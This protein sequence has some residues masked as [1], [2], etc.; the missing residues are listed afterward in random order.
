MG[1]AQD[2]HGRGVVAATGLE[3]DEAVLDNIDAADAVG[4]AE[5]VERGEELDAVGVRLLGCDELR[6][7]A[8]LEM[9]GN[10]GGLVGGRERRLR[11]GPHVVRGGDVG[12][13]EDA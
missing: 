4:V 2:G 1:E 9:D 3:T 12:V 8:L 7:D 6:G 10:V 13:F 5:L 11:H